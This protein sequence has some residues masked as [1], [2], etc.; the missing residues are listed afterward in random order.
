MKDIYVRQGVAAV[1]VEIG[2]VDIKDK[3]A[4]VG[5]IRLQAT[6]GNGAS[7]FHLGE[8]VGVGFLKWTF[9]AVRWGRMSG[10]R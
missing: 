2:R 8:Q 1:V 6:G 10:F 4:V 9:H 3:F 7:S 5:G